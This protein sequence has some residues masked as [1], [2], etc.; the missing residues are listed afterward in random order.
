MTPEEAQKI[1]H[2]ATR[3][4]YAKCQNDYTPLN[5]QAVILAGFQAVIDAVTRDIDKDYALKHLEK[6]CFQHGGL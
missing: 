4:E 2:A 6:S 1:Y 5:Q 3:Q